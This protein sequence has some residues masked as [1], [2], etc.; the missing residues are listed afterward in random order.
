[1]QHLRWEGNSNPLEFYGGILTKSVGD[2]MKLRVSVAKSG[3][4]SDVPTF[5]ALK[6]FNLL[7]G[8]HKDL[9][10]LCVHTCRKI[11]I[12][13]KFAGFS[14]IRCR[15]MCWWWCTV[16]LSW[17]PC[18]YATVVVG[19]FRFQFFTTLDSCLCL[20]WMHKWKSRGVYPTIQKNLSSDEQFP[21]KAVPHVLHHLD[22]FSLRRIKESSA[23]FRWRKNT[24][25]VR[26]QSTDGL[27]VERARNE[28][29]T[30]PAVVAI[31]RS[32]LRS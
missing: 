23:T 4:S 5:R 19:L 14:T 8:Q 24:A 10:K 28:Q 3:I 7:L 21:S 27:S 22:N 30:T 16:V 1:M 17:R 31:T 18:I 25:L 32:D 26:S 15:S 12:M 29:W 9:G 20:K 6:K 11:S 13:L 2:R